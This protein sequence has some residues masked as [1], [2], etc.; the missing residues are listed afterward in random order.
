M[1][2]GDKVITLAERDK[3]KAQWEKERAAEYKK[4]SAK[5]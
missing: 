5:K 1:I 2:V 4:L 3:L